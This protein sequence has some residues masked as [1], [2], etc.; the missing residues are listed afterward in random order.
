MIE[1]CRMSLLIRKWV[2]DNYWQYNKFVKSTKICVLRQTNLGAALRDMCNA[3]GSILN[4]RVRRCL[5]YLANEYKSESLQSNKTFDFIN[6]HASCLLN[7]RVQLIEN[8]ESL[9]DLGE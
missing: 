4:D 5:D 2:L 6:F 9:R 1:I 7:E 3:H 8:I